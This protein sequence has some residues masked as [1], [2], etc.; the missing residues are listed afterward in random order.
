MDNVQLQGLKKLVDDS[1]AQADSSL[2]SK[3]QNVLNSLKLVGLYDDK[4]LE[5]LTLVI[6]TD[7]FNALNNEVF[8]KL[9]EEDLTNLTSAINTGLT[10]YQQQMLVFE[11][12]KKK[13]G[14][15]IEV[16]AT[17]LY[18]Q[19]MERLINDASNYLTLMNSLKTLSD[20]E[21]STAIELI[22]NGSGEQAIE[23]VKSKGGLVQTTSH[24]DTARQVLKLLEENRVQEAKDILSKSL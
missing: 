13:S 20:E 9:N 3:L 8:S 5:K 10:P 24:N 1:Y 21:C 2:I 12:Y 11:L 15:D 22:K 16:Y 17:E 7:V 4:M 19:T 6:E 18:E 23:Y 14:K